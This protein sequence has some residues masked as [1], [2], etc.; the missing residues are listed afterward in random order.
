MILSSQLI[1]FVLVCLAAAGGVTEPLR[2]RRLKTRGLSWSFM[3]G[4]SSTLEELEQR[5]RALTRRRQQV[6][7]TQV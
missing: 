2:K 1:F 3:L 5:V 4:Y 6:G 7:L